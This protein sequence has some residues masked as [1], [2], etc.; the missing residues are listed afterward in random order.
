LIDAYAGSAGDEAAARAG[1]YVSR[2]IG[3]A[4]VA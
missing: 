1:A 2:L 3:A 4:E